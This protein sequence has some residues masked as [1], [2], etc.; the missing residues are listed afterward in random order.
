MGPCASAALLHW[1]GS[2]A[3][4]AGCMEKIYLPTAL[5]EAMIAQARAGLPEET[6]GL[7]AGRDGHGVRLH[8]IEN[9]RHSSVAYEMDPL[10]QIKAMIAIEND[11]LDLLAIYHSHPD[12]PAQ[13]SPT[14]L[15]Q[16]YY[17]EQA[18][19]IISLAGSERATL[20]GFMIAG[21]LITEIAVIET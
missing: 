15:A 13:P 14:D 6:C 3:N 7:I 16:A 17:P 11:G 18:Q 4:I 8:P 5:V 1:A 12:G 19:L 20:R 10:Q 21:G 2:A 9:S